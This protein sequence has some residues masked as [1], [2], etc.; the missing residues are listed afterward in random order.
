MWISTFEATFNLFL[1]D[2]EAAR[3]HA[4]RYVADLMRW[5]NYTFYSG[6]RDSR[7]DEENAELVE[8]M[9]RKYE[10]A[11]ADGPEE[12]GMNLVY[13]YVRI[14]KIYPSLCLNCFE[15]LQLH[16]TCSAV[17]Y[18]YSSLFNILTRMKTVNAVE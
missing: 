13:A 12:H 11:V 15:K 10:D 18:A 8:E 14:F 1:G 6:L 3:R 5:S 7:S 16:S 9:W 2:Q 4:Q 17:M